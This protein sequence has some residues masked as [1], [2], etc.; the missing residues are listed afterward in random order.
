MWKV[1]NEKKLPYYRSPLRKL[2]LA[3]SSMLF[4]GWSI[5]VSEIQI[6]PAPKAHYKE[7]VLNSFVFFHN[8]V[9]TNIQL[10]LQH[11]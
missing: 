10:I 11:A 4:R 2:G 1:K 6:L 5:L 3:S 8:D 7:D 9:K